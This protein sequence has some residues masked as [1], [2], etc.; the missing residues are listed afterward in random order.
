[1]T[2][3]FPVPRSRAA[4]QAAIRAFRSHRRIPAIVAAGLLTLL[5]LLVAAETI[6]AFFG[7]PLRLLPYDALLAWASRTLWSDPQALTASAIVALVGLAALAAA[8][9]PGRPRMMPVHTGDPDLIIGL[10]PKSV[11]RALAHAAEEVPGV[12]SARAT[13]RGARIIVTPRIEGPDDGIGQAVHDAVLT[14][15]A[16]LDSVKP[17]RVIV[18]VRERG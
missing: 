13:L 16:A 4:D 15:L 3:V 10:R 18:N 11:T 14:K 2:A 9:V 1:M 17:Y 8:L 7:H 5:G 12:L 6:S